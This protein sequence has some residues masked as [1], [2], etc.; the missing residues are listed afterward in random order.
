[1]AALSFAAA[2]LSALLLASDVSA[3]DWLKG[4]YGKR[5]AHMGVVE[6]MPYEETH[7]NHVPLVPLADSDLP[8]AP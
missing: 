5:P 7:Y 6:E 3:G 4:K 2:A 8:G 1:M